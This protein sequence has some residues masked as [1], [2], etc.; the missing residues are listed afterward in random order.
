VADVT[1]VSSDVNLEASNIT[2][3]WGDAPEGIEVAFSYQYQ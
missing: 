1:E 3:D 2:I